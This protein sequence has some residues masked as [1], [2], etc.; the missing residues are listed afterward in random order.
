[1]IKTVFHFGEL[2]RKISELANGC[3]F[4]N[5]HLTK[6]NH[7][8]THMIVS[9]TPPTPEADNAKFK[10]YQLGTSVHSNCLSTPTRHVENILPLQKRTSRAI[11]R[12]S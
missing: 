5:E 1:M 6:K 12:S 8:T 10:S 3:A 11:E 9:K 4:V 7:L 2:S